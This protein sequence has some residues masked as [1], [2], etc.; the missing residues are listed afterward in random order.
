MKVQLVSSD[1]DFWK[2]INFFKLVGECYSYLWNCHGSIKRTANHET[3]KNG[4]EKM[5]CLWLFLSYE[6]NNLVNI[7]AAYEAKYC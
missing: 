7:T 4:N 5:L 6:L 1:D 3:L 2:I